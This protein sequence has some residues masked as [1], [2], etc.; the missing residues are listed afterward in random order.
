MKTVQVSRELLESLQCACTQRERECGHRISCRFPELKQALSSEVPAQV[1][2][3]EVQDPYKCT[4]SNAVPLDEPAALP[5]SQPEAVADDTLTENAKKM[6]DWHWRCADQQAKVR[7]AWP[8]DSPMHGY[9]A[10]SC[11]KHAL[12]A[13]ILRSLLTPPAEAEKRIEAALEYDTGRDT[14]TD[15]DEHFRRG[16]VH[17]YERALAFLNGEKS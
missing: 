2:G 15:K 7:D 9:Y 4:I 8:E 10:K 3:R 13:S 5:P 11:E 6:I 14:Y 16:C 17:A 1:E 12:T